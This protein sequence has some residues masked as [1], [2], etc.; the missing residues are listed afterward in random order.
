MNHPTGRPSAYYAALRDEEDAVS[1][2]LACIR[3]EEDERRITV[4]Q[5]AAERISLLE[6]HLERLA[7]LRLEHLGG[8]R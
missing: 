7:K 4:A 2:A 3:A 1:D 8:T 6:G 5:A